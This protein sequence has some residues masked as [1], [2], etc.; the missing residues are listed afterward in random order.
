LWALQAAAKAAVT[1][2]SCDTLHIFDIQ[3]SDPPPHRECKACHRDLTQEAT[4]PIVHCLN[5]A[6]ICAN[7]CHYHTMPPNPALK[8]ICRSN[9][10]PARHEAAAA[11]R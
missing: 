2:P 9:T 11:Q 5:T 7:P 10:P 1:C 3:I 6:R 8:R 4:P